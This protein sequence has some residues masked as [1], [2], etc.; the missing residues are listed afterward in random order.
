VQKDERVALTAQ[1]VHVLAGFDSRS[2]YR[3]H[4]RFIPFQGWIVKPSCLDIFGSFLVFSHSLRLR[5]DVIYAKPRYGGEARLCKGGENMAHT[6][7]RVKHN[8][9]GQESKPARKETG[10]ELRR[11]SRAASH[12][13]LAYAHLPEVLDGLTYPVPKGTEGWITH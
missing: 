10:R 13:A 3:V 2:C 1:W 4:P 7:R 5:E 9:W 12:E 11:E 8:P 6:T